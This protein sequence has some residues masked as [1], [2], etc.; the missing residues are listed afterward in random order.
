MAAETWF[1]AI[2]YAFVPVIFT[3]ILI[4]SLVF[5][6]QKIIEK[7][8]DYVFVVLVLVLISS[9]CMCVFYSI[10]TPI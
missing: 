9:L 1:L 5:I 7:R 4:I 8:F 2:F 10:L 3:A 6:V